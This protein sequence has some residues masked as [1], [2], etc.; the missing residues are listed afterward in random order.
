M[1]LLPSLI[2]TSTNVAIILRLNNVLIKLVCAAY[3]VKIGEIMCELWSYSSFFE[4][5]KLVE[6][7][8]F[9][10]KFEDISYE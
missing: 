2:A 8:P 3:R 5:S 10:I 4:S 1:F 6:C 9:L 7:S